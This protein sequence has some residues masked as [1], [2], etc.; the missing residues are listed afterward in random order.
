M[1]ARSGEITAPCGVPTS[2]G[3]TSP[4]SITP[5]FSHLRIR[6]TTRRSPMR[7]STKRIRC[8]WSTVS[9]KPAMSASRMK[10]TAV[11]SSA[12]ARASSASCWL[13][14]ARKPWFDRLTMRAEAEEDL[15][16][17]GVQQFDRRPLDDLILQRRD[18]ER[19]LPPV[20]LGN[21]ATARWS[22]PVAATVDAGVQVL[23]PCFQPVAV[24]QP[25]HPVHPRCRFPLELEVAP[26][27]QVDIDVVEECSELLRGPVPCRLPYARQSGGH[28]LPARCP[29]HASPARVPH[30]PGPSLHRLR[31]RL[32][33]GVRRL[34]CYYGWV[35]L[36]PPVHHRLRP[37][38]LPDADR[39][40]SARRSDRRS[41][42]SRTRSVR[43]CRGL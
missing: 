43:A 13:R 21:V 4:S 40:A 16:V 28:A 37:S 30:G 26:A 35:R 3:R 9:K 38:G 20:R 12:T 34:R 24:V 15:L 14:P 7:C 10:F 31:R 29:V 22:R 33:G 32:P 39:R 23:K 17:D 27:Q 11:R 41:P 6:R 19:P 5:A 36:L 25:R 1:L 42:G 18:A 8:S 2:P